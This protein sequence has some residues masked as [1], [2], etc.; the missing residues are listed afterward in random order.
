MISDRP[1]NIPNPLWRSP[2]YLTHAIAN[3]LTVDA[4][5]KIDIVDKN[6]IGF[7]AYLKNDAN[8]TNANSREAFE[9]ALELFDIQFV[10]RINFLS[11]KAMLENTDFG[12]NTFSSIRIK[13]L[14]KFVG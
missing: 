10:G 13:R 1:L 4:T 3:Y 14:K 7:L 8:F 11:F 12:N 5:P 6:F 2:L 9:I